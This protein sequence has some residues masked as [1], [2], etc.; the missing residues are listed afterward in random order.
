MRPDVPPA[1]PTMW[2]VYVGGHVAASLIFLYY[3]SVR[4][5][6]SALILDQ[7]GEE[8][9]SGLCPRTLRWTSP[10]RGSL[11][12]LR[13]RRPAGPATLEHRSFGSMRLPRGRGKI[14]PHRAEAPGSNVAPAVPGRRRRLGASLDAAC[15]RDINISV[16][17]ARTCGPS[18]TSARRTAQRS[19]LIL[20]QTNRRTINHRSVNQGGVLCTPTSSDKE[21]PHVRA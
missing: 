19:S 18:L 16:R 21:G 9:V 3:S 7:T 17:Q 4:T 14:K 2:A 5:L 11:Q 12:V 6:D 10:H 20:N 8:Q 15:T 13:L 1:R